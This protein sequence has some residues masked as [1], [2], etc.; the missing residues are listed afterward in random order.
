MKSE[1][2]EDGFT[3]CEKRQGIL[4]ASGPM[5]VIGGP[6]SG[7]TTIALLKARRFAADGMCPEQRVLFLSF[8]NAAIR[9][10][11]E[12]ADRILDGDELRT[13]I[14]IKTYHSFAWEILR[15]HGYL[16][17]SQRRLRIISAQDADVRRA[18]LTNE[19][20]EL[21]QERLF[22]EE[23]MLAYDQ[24]APKAVELLERCPRLR[25]L[26]S[27]VHPLIVV[28][29]FQD[30]DSAQWKLVRL[31]SISS[32]IIAMGD[33][34]QQIYNWR[35]GVEE[36]RLDEFR[37][38]LNATVF[39]FGSEN[40]RSPGTGIAAYGQALLVPGTKLPLCNEM[41]IRTV[42]RYQFP[43]A[44]KL[45]TKQA[46]GL[47]KDA[48]PGTE[49]SIAVA[50]RSKAIVRL[51]SDA[52][53]DSQTAKGHKHGPIQHD[54]LIDQSQVLLSA[55]VTSYLLEAD[56]VG[57][58]DGLATVT[59]L[60]ADMHR[61]GGKKTH[62]ATAARLDKWASAIREGKTPKTKMIKALAG[63]LNTLR[64]FPWSGSPTADWLAIRKQLES[65]QVDELL[66]VA[67]HVRFLRVL[68]RGSLIED[69]LT[70][71]WQKQG[72]YQ[73]AMA[74]VEEAIT[75]EQVIDT[76]RPPA[77]CTVMTMHQLKAREYD[78]VV[79]A[80]DQYHRFLARN[81]SSP[82]MDTRRLLQVCVTRARHHVVIVTSRKDS[83]LQ[84]LGG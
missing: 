59:E 46:L 53:S 68:R 27:A 63:L 60:V 20:W 37:L 45:A 21:E 33:A 67:E 77:R 54:V 48:S 71:L 51:I 35:P 4:E 74:A 5:L 55:R 19:E 23:G 34:G 52:L 75:R 12:G 29:E 36:G 7:K 40:N 73:G 15:A 42:A 13:H 30:T 38:E 44:V 58:D 61:A 62:L 16:L 25:E 1:M 56:C 72:N 80:E 9:R 41:K 18:G 22:V 14:A 6:G 50:G 82:Y 81:E 69:E 79:L 39:D 32:C 76:V 65:L 84:L 43:L 3:L 26:Y 31:L 10:L 70:S 17:S 49:P 64:E 2:P 28:D 8:S 24:F 57:A 11:V 66:K 47:A 83:T 78:A